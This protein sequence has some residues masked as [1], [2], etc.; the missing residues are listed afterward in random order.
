MSKRTEFTDIIKAEIFVRDRATCCFSG[1][2]LWILDYG[3]S[4][5]YEIDWVDHIKPAS[6][7]GKST[8]ENGL[9]V[10][11]LFNFKKQAN[12]HDNIVFFE[13][14]FP[15][16]EF[17]E[18]FEEIPSEIANNL[19]RFS[20]LE[21]SD[22][23]FNRGLFRIMCGVGRIV[24]SKDDD[25]NPYKRDYKYYAKSAL[26][27][28]SKWDK[29]IAKNTLK[30]RGIINSPLRKEQRILFNCATCNNEAEIIKNMRL[31]APYYKNGV[32]CVG[33]MSN[34]ESDQ[35]LQELRRFLKRGR[36]PFRLK[37]IMRRNIE[38]VSIL[39]K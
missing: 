14:G 31:L 18:Y 32:A 33:R 13:D 1:K 34:A 39:F 20:K 19:N 38:T 26:K 35:D 4:P 25:K 12:A 23:Y 2:S 21:P 37:T 5:T 3:A 9:C 17:Y 8:L 24:F 15:T 11:Y 27:M 29:L 10:S 6:K 7:G 36:V 28:F 16:Y 22:W 30:Q